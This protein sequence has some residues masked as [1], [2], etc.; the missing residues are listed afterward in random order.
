MF[1]FWFLRNTHSCRC[2][3]RRAVSSKGNWVCLAGLLLVSLS[4]QA[5]SLSPSP[6]G[7]CHTLVHSIPHI[8]G[9]QRR[10]SQWL[11]YSPSP[12]TKVRGRALSPPPQWEMQQQLEN[13]RKIWPLPS[14]FHLQMSCPSLPPIC[15]F[16]LG[17]SSTSVYKIG[18][19][20]LF[21]N[22][23]PLDFNPNQ[24]SKGPI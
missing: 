17:T 3:W 1:L 12:L 9:P 4:P 8:L 20:W 15:K 24:A 18:A 5:R 14:Y 19:A 10:L 7:M 6:F 21:L 16:Q 23:Q 2:W 11:S 13:Y 22:S